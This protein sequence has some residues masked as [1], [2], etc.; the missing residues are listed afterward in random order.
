MIAIDTSSWIAYLSGA[1]GAD[2]A[3][4][5]RL[6]TD[7]QA[8]L[9]PVVLTELLS[10]PQLPRRVEVLFRSLPLL[11]VTDGYWER[12][13]GLRAKLIGRRRRARLADTLIA[14]SCLDHDVALVTRD[15]DFRHFSRV[16]RLKLLV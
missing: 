3:I 8:C 7:R 6:L 9:P 10:D 13:G 12:A 16:A 15:A 5:E 4:V 2:V 1:E 14:Q 11:P